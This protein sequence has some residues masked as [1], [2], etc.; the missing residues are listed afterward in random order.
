M[1]Q[2]AVRVL[3]STN[4]RFLFWEQ[5]QEFRGV[6]RRFRGKSVHKVDTK[7]R[8]S[9]PAAFRRVLEEGD[10]DWRSGENPQLVIVHGIKEGECLEGYS[11]DAMEKVDDLISSLP[12]FSPEREFYET[13]MDTDSDYATV[14][15][16][17]RMVV[18]AA[19]RAKIGVSKEIIFVGKGETFQMWEP[20]AYDEELKRIKAW[21][22]AQENPHA[23]L[24]GTKQEG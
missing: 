19:L 23:M 18:S 20:A 6:A 3:G 24:Y 15:E 17:G 2:T 5:K 21:G 12:H 7:G 16:N 4:R 13:I 11:I 22:A 10:P 1:G 8:V 14:D 9:I